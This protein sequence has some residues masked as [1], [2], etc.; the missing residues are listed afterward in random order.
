MFTRQQLESGSFSI[1]NHLIRI[2]SPRA[3]AIFASP[4]PPRNACK[5]AGKA[6]AE[7]KPTS[8]NSNSSSSSSSSSSNGGSG[9]SVYCAVF[10]KE[11][12]GEPAL[13]EVY[14][15]HEKGEATIVAKKSFFHAQE[16][17]CQWAYDGRALLVKTHT[18]ASDLTYYGS[19]ALYFLKVKIL[20]LFCLS[21]REKGSS[22]D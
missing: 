7:S 13:L 10:S 8:S 17:D 15:L 22:E 14:E 1:N 4:E 19:S 16:A 12:K 3:S 2:N 21:S 18:D 6:A 5:D 20:M 11:T 9:G